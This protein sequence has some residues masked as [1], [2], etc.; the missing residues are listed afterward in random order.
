MAYILGIISKQFYPSRVYVLTELEAAIAFLN[1]FKSYSEQLSQAANFVLDMNILL[2][3]TYKLSCYGSCSEGV[4]LLDEIKKEL[5]AGETRLNL[6]PS[7]Q[8][9]IVPASFHKASAEF[10]RIHG[11]AASFYAS[12]LQYLSFTPLESLQPAEKHTFA[13]DI[14]LAALV[15][16][17]VYSFGD[18]NAHPILQ[19][20]HG[21]PQAWLVSLLSSFQTGD[22]DLFNRTIAENQAAFNSQAALTAAAPTMKEKISILAAMEL[23]LKRDSKKR[24]LTFSDLASTTQLPEDQV[25]WL[26]MRAM[27]L[28]LIKGTIDQ[29]DK[30]RV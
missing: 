5:S 17:N 18:I 19:S 12:A 7:G 16:D 21:T 26:M 8:D 2:L 23:A 24:S 22:I 4:A 20:L 25:E 15:A 28:G 14:A 10:Y 27:S 13:V 29:V 9:T 30:V 1:N 6:L 3:K 11:P